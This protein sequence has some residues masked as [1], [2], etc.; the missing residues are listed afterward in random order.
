MILRSKICHWKLKGK[1]GNT[2]D[3]TQIQRDFLKVDC[4]R[5]YTDFLSYLSIGKNYYLEARN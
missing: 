3:F 4:A 2:N 5:M 1:N